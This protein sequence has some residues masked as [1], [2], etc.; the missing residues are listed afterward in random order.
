MQEKRE[1]KCFL[2]LLGPAADNE[3]RF[4]LTLK[5]STDGDRDSSKNCLATSPCSVGAGQKQRQKKAIL[6]MIQTLGQAG[7]EY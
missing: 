5:K 1:Q 6:Q 3:L 7:G 4:I 2:L